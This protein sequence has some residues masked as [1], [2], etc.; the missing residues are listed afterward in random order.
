VSVASP[1][2]TMT[3]SNQANV[4]FRQTY[5]SDVFKGT[6]TKTLVFVRQDGRWLIQQEKAG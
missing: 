1:K 2:V 5:R 6:S 4:T 3:G